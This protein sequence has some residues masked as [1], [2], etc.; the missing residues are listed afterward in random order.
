MWKLG[1]V[2]VIWDDSFKQLS[3]EREPIKDS[4]ITEWRK[5]GYTHDTFSG[6]M[7]GSK[8]TMPDWVIET[9]KNLGLENCGYVI[10]EMNTLEIMPEHI[11]HYETYCK[12]FN[13]SRDQVHRAIVFLENWKPGHYS[14]MNKTGIVNWKAGDYVLWDADVPHAAANIGVLPR[15]T[16]QITGTLWNKND[17]L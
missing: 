8:N 11:D 9:G 16:L 6:K 10:Y 17:S 5:M 2:P 13:I 1:K 4:E 14:E 12:V 3:F 7:Y 15:Y